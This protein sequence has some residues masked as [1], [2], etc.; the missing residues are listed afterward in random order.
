VP[1]EKVRVLRNGVDLKLFSPPRDRE[2]A[3]RRFGLTGP[4]MVSVGALIERK[5]H[6]ITIGAL[7]NLPGVRLL[8]AGKGAEQ[9]NL[10]ALAKRLG[11]ADR[12]SFLGQQGHEVLPEL[13]AA[14]DLSV[15]SSSREG[16][17]N[18]LLE[19]MACGTPVV[20]TAI[21]GTPEVVAVPE[22]GR[23]MAARTAEACAE[24]VKALLA[25]PPDRAATR[26]YAEG[27]SWDATTQGQIELFQSILTR[28]HNQ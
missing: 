12:V 20:A 21:W 23:L 2:A 16:W 19:S 18:V 11:V 10:E 5:G 8:L 17:A 7:P 6:H 22:A 13:Y 27:F 26:A 25:D 28:R 3:R 4:T 1:D 24:A 14:A 9:A 15:L